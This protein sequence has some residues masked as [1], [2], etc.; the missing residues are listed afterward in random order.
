M[1]IC[2]CAWTRRHCLSPLGSKQQLRESKIASVGVY[3]VDSWWYPSMA[4]T[5]YDT[6]ITDSYGY[7]LAQPGPAHRATSAVANAWSCSKSWS[8]VKTWA[9]TLGTTRLSRWGA[10][11]NIIRAPRWTFLTF[12]VLFSEALSISKSVLFL[13]LLTSAQ[14]VWHFSARQLFTSCAWSIFVEASLLTF[15]WCN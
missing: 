6:L 4:M 14:A 1:R 10:E 12:Q 13:P 3:A 7:A 15:F 8:C 5:D 11:V 9:A 2:K